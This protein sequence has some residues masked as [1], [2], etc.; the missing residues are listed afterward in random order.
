MT[1]IKV[2]LVED[3][4]PLRTGISYLLEHEPEINFIGAYATAEDALMALPDLD[5]PDVAVVDLG[6]PGMSGVEFIR[7]LNDTYP[8][9][10]SLVF[11]IFADKT[12][13]FDACKA[14]AFGYLLKGADNQEVLDAIRNLYLGNAYISS[15]IAGLTIQEFLDASLDGDIMLSESEKKVLTR[16][17]EGDTYKE[18]AEIL[19]LSVNT[20]KTYCKRIYSKLHVGNKR[21]AVNIAKQKQIID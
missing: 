20:I 14:G 9:V 5:E 12:N 19:G 8:A 11:T 17:A 13:V 1:K 4:E 18:A 7:K 3:E 6:L 16:L 15:K 21:R 2:L 10:E